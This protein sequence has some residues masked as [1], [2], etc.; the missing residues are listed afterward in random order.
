MLLLLANGSS[1]ARGRQGSS[2]A[3]GT[4]SSSDKRGRQGSSRAFQG[5]HAPGNV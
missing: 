3:R 1:D 4:Q 2:D 5:Q